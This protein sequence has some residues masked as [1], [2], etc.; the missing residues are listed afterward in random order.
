MSNLKSIIFE[1]KESTLT[2]SAK[3]LVCSRTFQKNLV[4][5]DL[6]VFY[7]R[8][9]DIYLLVMRNSNNKKHGCTQAGY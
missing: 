9:Y 7:K 5:I 6:A 2:I 8:K 1:T 4:C 3:R